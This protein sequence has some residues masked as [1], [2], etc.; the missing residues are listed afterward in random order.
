MESLISI[1]IP[2]YNCAIYLKQTIE[3]ILNQKEIN[4]NLLDIEVID[5]C[6]TSDNPEE[7]VKEF[8]NGKVKFYK[9]PQNVGAIA[10]FNTC[11][12][13]CKSEWIHILHGD[14]LVSELFYSKYIKCISEFSQ[15]S[16]ISSRVNFIDID[17]RFIWEQPE[18]NLP[19]NTPFTTAELLYGNSF[20]T[21]S[22][23]VKKIVYDELGV[24]KIQ[25]NHTADWEMW[26]RILF[27]KKGV[28]INDILSSWRDFQDSDTKKVRK[29]GEEIKDHY[30]AIKEIGKFYAVKNI[31]FKLPIEIGIRNCY[32]FIK[33]DDFKSFYS[34][35]IE[36]Y[37]IL[38]KKKRGEITIK[39]FYFLIK[40]KLKKILK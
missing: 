18:F 24:F 11:I 17:S 23:M 16:F 9:Q 36:L 8:G 33:I 2:T 40:E 31:S 26:A 29:S 19:I 5:D 20:A 15:I 12:N 21:P 32:Y 1:K 3:S 22:V 4:L 27:F 30:N 25:L 10:N 28:L 13:R 37:K 6:S 39:F 7:I 35:Y 38:G 34:N 14:D